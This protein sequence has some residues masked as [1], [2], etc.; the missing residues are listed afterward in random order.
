L[1]IFEHNKKHYLTINDHTFEILNYFKDGY[2]NPVWIQCTTNNS[3]GIVKEYLPSASWALIKKRINRQM[4]FI[5]YQKRYFNYKTTTDYPGK[6]AFISTKEESAKQL[7]YHWLLQHYGFEN[8][9]ANRKVVEEFFEDNMRCF[10]S[11]SS[12]QNTLDGIIINTKYWEFYDGTDREF[13][14]DHMKKDEEVA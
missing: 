13:F 11:L 7:C 14:K 4:I 10:N 12:N 9:K 5:L 3:Y 1:K 6:I 8:N 2:N